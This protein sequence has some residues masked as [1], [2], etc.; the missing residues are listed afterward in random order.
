M[1]HVQNCGE[2]NV[3]MFG[4]QGSEEPPETNVLSSETTPFIL[5]GMTVILAHRK[6]MTI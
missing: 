1:E 3:L 4:K 5:V 2:M 6:K